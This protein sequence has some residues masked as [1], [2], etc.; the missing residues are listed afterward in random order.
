MLYPTN[1]ELKEKGKRQII[2]E[3]ILDFG[4]RTKTI[5]KYLIFDRKNLGEK[6][7]IKFHI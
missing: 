3:K 4:D 6:I 1:I 2:K 5:I 7:L